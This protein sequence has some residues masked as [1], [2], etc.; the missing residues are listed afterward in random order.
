MSNNNN[1]DKIVSLSGLS[2][3][4]TRIREWVESLTHP[5]T[6]KYSD[7][8]HKSQEYAL[9]RE[10]DQLIDLSS[11]IQYAVTST[12]ASRTKNLLTVRNTIGSLNFNGS[13]E[14]VKFVIPPHTTC[15]EMWDR[16]SEFH[17]SIPSDKQHAVTIEP[18]SPQK[19]NYEITMWLEGDCI[20]PGCQATALV[21]QDSKTGE[22]VYCPAYMDGSY[23][24][25]VN[26]N[27][28]ED[29]YVQNTQLKLTYTGEYYYSE[30]MD[31]YYD[32]WVV[33]SA[34]CYIISVDGST[35][36]PVDL[37]PLYEPLGL[38]G[39]VC[40]LK[41]GDYVYF[42]RDSYGEYNSSMYDN[43]DGVCKGTLENNSSKTYR[44]KKG[45]DNKPNISN[46][47]PWDI[48]VLFPDGYMFAFDFVMDRYLTGNYEEQ[49]SY[50]R[51]TRKDI[52]K[53][54]TRIVLNDPLEVDV[55]LDMTSS[56]MG[57]G[58]EVT[59]PESSETL[60][61][62]IKIIRDSDCELV[63]N[64]PNMKKLEE[65]I[66]TILA[67]AKLTDVDAWQV[68]GGGEGF[69]VHKMSHGGPDNEW[70]IEENVEL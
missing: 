54:S 34:H 25:L 30:I 67:G 46:P 36:T 7:N 60:A 3:A 19:E 48:C 47:I 27:Y 33:T 5:T 2:R 44:M 68:P 61:R 12:T 16:D 6:F 35:K 49:V 24:D 65:D 8:E 20:N 66:I 52:S 14:G 37:C 56:N 9:K 38:Q 59:L 42:A 28:Y 51:R 63:V 13:Y 21:Y 43:T 29:F 39:E 4:V 32:K 17:Y 22:K 69:T 15:L 31:D 57:Y 53:K 70:Y 10:A 23:K 11:G 55:I 45:S 64:G 41:P 1:T 18:G 26:M 62:P 40:F 50:V 58:I